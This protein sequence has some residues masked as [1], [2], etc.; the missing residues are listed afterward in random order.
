M[1]RGWHGNIVFRPSTTEGSPGDMKA[2]KMKAYVCVYRHP[3]PD[4]NDWHDTQEAAASNGTLRQFLD[5]YNDNNCYYD[6][7][8]DP[9]FFAARTLLG[10]VYKERAQHLMDRCDSP[11]L[12]EKW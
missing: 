4:P 9:S 7:G 1:K 3:I 12:D 8:D 11:L 10:D 2:S 5:V 6:S